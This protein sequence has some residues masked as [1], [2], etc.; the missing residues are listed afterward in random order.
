MQ[1]AEAGQ[2][3]PASMSSC[4]GAEE[5]EEAGQSDLCYCR[6]GRLTTISVTQWL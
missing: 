3:A 4:K 5:A 1:K 2:V 6:A